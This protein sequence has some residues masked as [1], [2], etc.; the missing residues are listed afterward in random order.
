MFAAA[1]LASCETTV[2][3]PDPAPVVWSGRRVEIAT[4]GSA[5][6]CGGSRAFLDRFAGALIDEQGLE[7]EDEQKARIYLLTPE[8]LEELEFCPPGTVCGYGRFAYT[9]QALDKHEL[10]HA[11]RGAAYG[12][13]LPGPT[14]F[15]EGL[16]TLYG[17][18]RGPGEAEERDVFA[19]LDAAEDGLNGRVSTRWYPVGA[20]FMDF[21]ARTSSY[22][23]LS[24]FLEDLVGAS[25]SG[26]V[27]V[28]FEERFGASFDESVVRFQTDFP[29]CTEISRTRL[30]VECAEDPL[31][32]DENGR[33]EP[34][35]DLHC[36]DD[37]VLGPF[38]GKMWRTFTFEIETSQPI[39]FQAPYGVEG[40][41]LSAACPRTELEVVDCE[42]GCLAD[43][44][45]YV[46]W[47]SGA[48]GPASFTQETRQFEP[49]RYVVRLSRDVDDPGP[50]CAE[51]ELER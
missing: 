8:E 21:L 42:R 31:P 43:P 46:P 14:L 20:D 2:V 3:V 16:A 38:E 18:S 30:L 24:E 6:E 34:V 12:A 49:G 37:K 32:F 35:F 15:E 19:G 25:Q 51:I 1:V 26:D 44:E 4:N 10:V 9:D 40:D 36:D 13:E 28:P 11:V 50:A 7:L 47:W 41:D 23:V 33:L 45:L 48:N 17:G 5:V 22:R 39:H 27:A 29:V